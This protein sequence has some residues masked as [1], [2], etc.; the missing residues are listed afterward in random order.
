[1]PPLPSA[2][3]AALGLVVTVLDEAKTLP[4][5]AI[6]L[7]MVAISKALQFSLRAQR[8]YAALAA[9]GDEVLAARNITDAPPEWATFD[10]PVEDAVANGVIGA[11][12]DDEPS[13]RPAKSIR[14][15]RNG[16]PS[17]FDTVADD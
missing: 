12:V 16:K 1:M 11:A 13:A 15:P 6:E 10:A 5:K 9:R 17:A 8:S 2:V 7:P 14:A 3:R 4:D